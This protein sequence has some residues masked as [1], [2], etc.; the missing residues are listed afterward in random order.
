MKINVSFMGP[1]VFANLRR[2]LMLLLKYSLEDLGHQVALTRANVETGKWLNILISS[3]FLTNEDRIAIMQSGADVIHINTEVIKNDMLNFNPQKVDFLGSYLPFLRYGRGVWESVV[4]NLEEHRRYG[5]NADF[6]RWSFH[7]KL[8]EIKH[9]SPADKDLDFYLFG[10]MTDRR[11]AFVQ[12]LT[13]N[14][15]RGLTHHTCPFWER[16]SYIER[17]KVNLNIIQENVYTHVNSF[18]I[19]YLANNRCSML[20]EKEHD[21]AGYLETI[22]LADPSNFVE[23]F[24]KLIHQDNYLKQADETYYH[25]R[26]IHMTQV[27]QEAL[28]KM[29]ASKG[30]ADGIFPGT[31]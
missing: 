12:A 28:D 22:P 5:T 2:D 13:D 31:F 9:V 30:V 15:F 17:T 3:Y 4:D 19:G 14:G 24:A 21:P 11:K 16:N 29:M 20:S 7:E 6:L 1:E 26:K 10:M 27:M 18:R 25:F 23:M 8:Q